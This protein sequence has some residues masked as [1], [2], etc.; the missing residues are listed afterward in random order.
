MGRPYFHEMNNGFTHVFGHDGTKY[1]AVTGV[2]DGDTSSLE[3]AHK[4]AL[5]EFIM[6]VQNQS[7]INSLNI[8]TD[9]TE[10]INGLEVYKFE[11]TFDCGRDQPYEA[12]AIG[13]SFIMDDTPC[14]I[15]GYVDGYDSDTGERNIDQSLADE[16][17]QN[18]EAMIYTVRSEE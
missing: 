4:S 9:S 10:N 12:Y 18:V 15:I 17:K 3:A 8:E 14:N 5:D 11:G 2:Y 16:I 6:S 1:I 7:L 13:Y